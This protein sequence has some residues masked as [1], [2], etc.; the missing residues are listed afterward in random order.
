[1]TEAGN[2]SGNG[3]GHTGFTPVNGAVQE[4]LVVVEKVLHVLD[5]LSAEEPPAD[6]MARTMRRLEAES[7][8]DPA[9]LRPPELDPG[10]FIPHA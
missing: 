5:L 10:T 9:A 6:L 3:S 8:R 2:G 4:R 7:T 1:M